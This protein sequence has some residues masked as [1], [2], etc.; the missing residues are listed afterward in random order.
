LFLL[1][2][3]LEGWGLVLVESMSYGVVPVV[4]GSYEA[5]HDIIDD[6]VSG[7]V[8][9]KPYSCEAMTGRI[10]RL[11]DDGGLR[12][13]MASAAISAASRFDLGSIAARWYGLFD[14]INV[15]VL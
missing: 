11:M 8:V 15:R 4:Y 9:P 14:E 3:D 6:G 13:R 12:A 1:A 5:V 10:R 2:S 7:F